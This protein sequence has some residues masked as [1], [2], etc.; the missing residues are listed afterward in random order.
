MSALGFV[1]Q[2]ISELLAKRKIFQI[3]GRTR[4]ESQ[5][6]VR[7]DVSHAYDL[8]R[9]D[10]YTLPPLGQ[11]YR[12][13]EDLHA[14]NHGKFN[15][16]VT[17]YEYEMLKY[18]PSE[19]FVLEFQGIGEH[20]QIKNVMPDPFLTKYVLYCKQT[21]NGV[22][23]FPYYF[24]ELEVEMHPLGW[25]A[26]GQTVELLYVPPDHRYPARCGLGSATN[27]DMPNMWHPK[28]K[29]VAGTIVSGMVPEVR[30]LFQFLVALRVRSGVTHAHAQSKAKLDAR[31]G[32]KVG[33]YRYHVLDI[34]TDFAEDVQ[35]PALP[36]GKILTASGRAS[37]GR[38]WRRAHLR[39]FDDDTFTFI[40]RMRV[41]RI[42]NGIIEKDYRFKP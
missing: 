20:V 38:H 34:H 3:V 29:L 4:E 13:V 25:L 42:E 12:P 18:P 27:F 6:K 37:P 35:R 26:L 11:F 28:G 33:G 30:A 14:N 9:A 39:W 24:N 22:S 31:S 7:M 41:G 32:R 8:M 5:E 15:M 1:D 21:E 36:T 16:Y 19:E 23:F 17:D 2:I 40:R 10:K